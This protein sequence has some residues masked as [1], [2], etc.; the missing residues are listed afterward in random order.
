M[1]L[2]NNILSCT[3]LYIYTFQA[4][5]DVQTYLPVFIIYISIFVNN[6]SRRYTKP[7][8][9]IYRQTTLRDGRGRI[10]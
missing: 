6:Y 10:I 8:F 5:N 1:E 2:Y 3:F 9:A 4:T 7:I